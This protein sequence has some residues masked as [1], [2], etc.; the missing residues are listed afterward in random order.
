MMDPRLLGKKV[1]WK[2][3]KEDGSGLVEYR[4]GEG[5]IIGLDGPALKVIVTKKDS[6]E[7]K[8]KN[9]GDYATTT[10]H[11]GDCYYIENIQELFSKPLP[12]EECSMGEHLDLR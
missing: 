11:I 7:I 10:L 2:F 1:K 9:N 8:L 3:K 12:K 5:Y 6:R 4:E